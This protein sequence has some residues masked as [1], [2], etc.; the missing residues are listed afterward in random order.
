MAEE[1]TGEETTGGEQVVDETLL[2]GTASTEEEIAA[3]AAADAAAKTAAEEAAKKA[4]EDGKSEDGKDGKTDET[5]D[6]APENY[7]DFA[8]PE[9]MEMDPV[10]LEA[11]TPLAK[12]LELTQVQAQKLVDYEAARVKALVAAQDKAFAELNETWQAEARAD[13]EVGGDKFDASLALANKF[14]EKFGSPALRKAFDTTGMGNHPEIL[15]ALSRAGK[16]LGE[17]ALTSGVNSSVGKT[18]EQILYPDLP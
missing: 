12:E 15:R 14:L 4:A 9:G 6:G 2:G 1:T 13:E 18:R 3:K 5:A 17:D 11:F 8:L 16:F 7:E 10:A